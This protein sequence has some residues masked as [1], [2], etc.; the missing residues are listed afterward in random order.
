MIREKPS[1]SASPSTYSS[2]ISTVPRTAACS[3]RLDGHAGNVGKRGMDCADWEI[4]DLFIRISSLIHSPSVLLLRKKTVPVFEPGTKILPQIQ[5]MTVIGTST[6]IKEQV[7]LTGI[8]RWRAPGL[9]P[10][11]R[12]TD[13]HGKREEL[14]P[15]VKTMSPASLCKSNTGCSFIMALFTASLKRL[16]VTCLSVHGIR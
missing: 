11:I 14:I 10:N 9:D 7:Y 1:R 8:L 12:T 5:I 2:K 6:R 4:G 3:G 15:G 13:H 16:F